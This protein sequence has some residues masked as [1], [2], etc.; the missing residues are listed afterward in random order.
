LLSQDGSPVAV[1]VADCTPILLA[2]PET[3]HCAAVHAGWRGTAKQAVI[4]AVQAL[5][6][7]GGYPTQMI[8]SIGPCIG[9]CCF[10]IGDDAAG[11]LQDCVKH[12]VKH[13]IRKNGRMF[14]DLPGINVAQLLQAGLLPEH[15][16]QQPG[17]K[18]LC[19]CCDATHFFSYRRDGKLSGRHLAIV[20]LNNPA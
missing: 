4:H 17:G 2:D 7:T 19:T 8:A 14:A 3:G 1:R 20:A 13:C 6:K 16:E 15:I 12:G 18:R 5:Q 10:E 9:S 11:Q